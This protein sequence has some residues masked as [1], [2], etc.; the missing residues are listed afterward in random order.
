MRGVAADRRSLCRGGPLVAPAVR[1]DLA[2][3][4]DSQS[5]SPTN[6]T[7]PN[8]YKLALSGFQGVRK[9]H[10]NST[11]ANISA[12]RQRHNPCRRR[13]FLIATIKR[14]ELLASLTKQTTDAV[15]NRHKI[16]G[17]QFRSVR[18]AKLTT[19]Y[20]TRRFRPKNPPK[21]GIHATQLPLKVERVRQSL[22]IQK[23]RHSGISRNALAKTALILPGGHGMSLH[24]FVSLFV[25]HAMLHQILQ[26][27]P[28]EN[29]PLR[30]I[31]IAQHPRRKNFHVPNNVGHA[32]Q[33]VIHQN[34]G[35]GKND[36]LRRSC[37]KC[38]AHAIARY[39]PAPP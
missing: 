36:A 5:E 17:S 9:I 1:P 29:Q 39:F 18:K 2:A 22:G 7:I 37:A 12:R 11:L 26:Q 4:H 15:S 34:R 14:L 23:F 10:P 32:R 19:R 27:L 3:P 38:P 20:R 25:R 33:H 13:Q 35:I 24:R 16:A 30:R 31:Q 6:S 8:R 28:G 21:D